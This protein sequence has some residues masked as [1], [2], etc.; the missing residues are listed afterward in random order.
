MRH[1][2]R[3][4]RSGMF[5]F[6][7]EIPL[8]L[9][10]PAD[11]GL[12]TSPDGLAALGED[13]S[14]SVYY[15]TAGGSLRDARMMLSMYGLLT[16][17]SFG[18]KLRLKECL[19]FTGQ[20]RHGFSVTVPISSSLARTALA[21]DTPP[22]QAMPTDVAMRRLD[23]QEPLVRV[24]AIEQRRSRYVYQESGGTE[25]VS[26]TVDRCTFTAADARLTATFL[27][28][29]SYEWPAGGLDLRAITDRVMADHREILGYGRPVTS[30]YHHFMS[31]RG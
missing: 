5:S 27:E 15:D 4:W 30:K 28:S 31:Q 3:F 21:G 19:S 24:A 18:L 13:V 2:E 25:F 6:E 29:S 17:P 14:F 10:G 16:N 20:I 22:A 9:T 11:A 26:I 8:L 23:H 7:H 1:D 12:C